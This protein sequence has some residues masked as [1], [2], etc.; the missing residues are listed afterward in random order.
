MASE[1]GR[2]ENLHEYIWVRRCVDVLLGGGIAALLGGSL[3]MSTNKTVNPVL[4]PRY[5]CYEIPLG[6]QSLAQHQGGR[7]GR[8]LCAA[9]LVEAPAA[10][11]PVST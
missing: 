10:V 3:L 5:S 7:E 4:L 8:R 2:I 6:G 11:R 9:S 1:H